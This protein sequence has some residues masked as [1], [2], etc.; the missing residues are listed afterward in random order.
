MIT[1]QQSCHTFQR[2]NGSTNLARKIITSLKTIRQQMLIILR[3]LT[4]QSGHS[5]KVF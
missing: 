2:R 1:S 5:Y 4:T 3:P